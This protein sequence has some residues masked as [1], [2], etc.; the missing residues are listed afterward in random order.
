VRITK[1]EKQLIKHSRVREF[2]KRNVTQ[3]K[4][5]RH[6]VDFARK[7]CGPYRDS[8]I[9]YSELFNLYFE[10]LQE[11]IENDPAFMS[12]NT[13]L[14]SLLSITHS[15]CQLHLSYHLPWSQ[16][17]F[18]NKSLRWNQTV[19]MLVSRSVPG[20]I[21][22]KSFQFGFD[23]IDKLHI[24]VDL[25]LNL[26]KQV[27]RLFKE[28]SYSDIQEEYLLG[29]TAKGIIFPLRISSLKSKKYSI[30]LIEQAFKPLN[31]QEIT[32]II[33]NKN[34]DHHIR[35][36]LN[37]SSDPVDKWENPLL[38][39]LLR[40]NPI[41]PS[42]FLDCFLFGIVN[43]E[44]L[45]QLTKG[46][47]WRYGHLFVP[48]SSDSTQERLLLESRALRKLMRLN[49]L[50]IPIKKHQGKKI[51]VSGFGM[52]G[53]TSVSTVLCTGQPFMDE[54]ALTLNYEINTLR[55]RD[56][57]I[58]I[59][60]LGPQSAFLNRFTGELAEFIFSG[61][62][63]LIFVFDASSP[64]LPTARRYLEKEIKCLKQYSPNSP[65]YVLINK[66]DLIPEEK[67]EAVINTIKTSL[68]KEK[69]IL[70]PDRCFPISCRDETSVKALD[71]VLE[72][73]STVFFPDLDFST[74]KQELIFYSSSHQM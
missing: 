66:M 43:Y 29:I 13:K 33:E 53:V 73:F 25:D 18:L 56:T 5:E 48:G 36:S 15:R 32:Q 58:T 7:D 6:L 74:F 34:F 26:P 46:F 37:T 12:R 44:K 1:E 3:F 20:Y 54:P 64:A 47:T 27:L 60:D 67:H 28:P 42:N 8:E 11:N 59:V 2:F 50:D 23:G 40:E 19:R 17:S 61:V 31:N 39:L 10:F 68:N 24:K 22:L 71:I 45:Y 70:V 52:P 57:D 51:L 35:I 69:I 49:K 21:P 55:I 38:D 30:S 16:R 9:T 4:S 65:Y 14:I 62:Q 41:Y 72:N 63:A